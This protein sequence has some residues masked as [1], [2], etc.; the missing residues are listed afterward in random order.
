[1]IRLAQEIA[2]NEQ[3]FKNK[4]IARLKKYDADFDAY[5]KLRSEENKALGPIKPSLVNEIIDQQ[6]Q[7]VRYNEVERFGA[8]IAGILI[9]ELFTNAGIPLPGRQPTPA[10][11]ESDIAN[12]RR[13]EATLLNV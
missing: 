6:Y 1:M 8:L 13:R 2:A 4:I 7:Q 12:L 9:E 3:E 11:N 5:Q 10:D